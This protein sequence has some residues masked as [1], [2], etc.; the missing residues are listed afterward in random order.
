MTDMWIVACFN[1]CFKWKII[2]L[3]LEKGTF[4]GTFYDQI[5]CC[6]AVNDRKHAFSGWAKLAEN[7]QKVTK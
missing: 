7:G 5:F 2:T 1:F 3:I 4:E 6:L